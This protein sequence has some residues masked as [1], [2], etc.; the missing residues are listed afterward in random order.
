MN[1]VVA[2]I[3]GGEVSGSI[4]ESCRH[5]TSKLSHIHFPSTKRSADYLIRMGEEKYV[6]NFGCPV[7]DYI[8][9]LPDDLKNKDIS[10]GIGASID[11][12]KI[13]FGYI[14]P[15]NNEL[16]FKRPNPECA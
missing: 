10:G 2:H 12:N 1:L 16:Y 14:P 3:Q 11:L 8:L 13:Y 7:G 9:S 5:A 4:D 15:S 6:H